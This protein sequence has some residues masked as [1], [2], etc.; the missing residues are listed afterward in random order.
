MK[1]EILIISLL[2]LPAI[3]LS[4]FFF[5]VRQVINSTHST[6]MKVGLVL[7][8]SCSLVLLSLVSFFLL[9]F[10]TNPWAH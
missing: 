8:L 9:A 1:E 5:A 10:S 6:A 4:G 2:V 3:Y 7:V